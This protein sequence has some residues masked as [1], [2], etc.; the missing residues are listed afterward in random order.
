MG[1]RLREYRVSRYPVQAQM[2]TIGFLVERTLPPLFK[3]TKFSLLILS[4]LNKKR[5]VDSKSKLKSK[6]RTRKGK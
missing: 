1:G 4:F 2:T 6:Y 3:S 5:Q